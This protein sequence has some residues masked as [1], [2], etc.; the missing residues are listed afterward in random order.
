MARM[1]VFSNPI[2]RNMRSATSATSCLVCSL[3]AAIIPLLNVFKFEYGT[4]TERVQNLTAHVR[5]DNGV[6]VLI[7]P[8]TRNFSLSER[9]AERTTTNG[10]SH[11]FPL[12]P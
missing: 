2:S 10:T 5:W 9:C 6:T 4:E 8:V 11:A 12:R 3:L 7:Q 1:V